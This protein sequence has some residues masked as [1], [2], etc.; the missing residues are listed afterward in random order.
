MKSTLGLKCTFF[1]IS[2][3]VKNLLL[4]NFITECKQI[5]L[6]NL[7]GTVSEIGS[8]TPVNYFDNARFTTIPLKSLTD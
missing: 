7:K 3:V 1:P 2:H 4:F 8:D 5:I 6:N